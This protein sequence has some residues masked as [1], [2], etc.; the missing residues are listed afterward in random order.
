MVFGGGG[1]ASAESFWPDPPEHKHLH[2][3]LSKTRFPLYMPAMTSRLTVNPPVIQ[4][5]PRVHVKQQSTTLTVGTS[6]TT[7]ASLAVRVKSRR[8]LPVED[9]A[10]RARHSYI[11]RLPQACM[12]QGRHG[13]HSYTLRSPNGLTRVEVLLRGKAFV[14]KSGEHGDLKLSRRFPW[15]MS[16]STVWSAICAEFGWQ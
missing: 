14:V 9:S 8:V 16:P 13:E 15:G 6:S 12:P 11:S 3:V 5:S 10:W 1:R 2:R 4:K 7:A